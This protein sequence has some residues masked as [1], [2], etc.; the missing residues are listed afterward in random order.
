MQEATA[1]AEQRVAADDPLIRRWRAA[2]TQ[3]MMLADR[4]IVL[5]ESMRSEV[6]SR[7]IPETKITIAP[8]GCNPTATANRSSP[9]VLDASRFLK[10]NGALAVGLVGSIQR[11]EGVME[12]IEAIARLRCD[13]VRVRLLLAGS[14]RIEHE[15]N[16][17]IQERSLEHDVLLMNAVSPA[18]ALA[19]LDLLDVAVV[20]RQDSLVSRLV[21]PLKP[22]DAMSRGCCVVMSKSPRVPRDRSSR[23]NRMPC[24]S[25]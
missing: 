23:K 3:A 17:L 22:L 21:T 9:V 14:T 2:E 8:N 6:V 7:G 4:V 25:K 12:L 15:M 13:G 10:Q 16:A 5:G 24:R 19:I 11:L 1:V 20:A 18:E